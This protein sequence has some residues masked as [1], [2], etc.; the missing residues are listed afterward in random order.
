MTSGIR[1]SVVELH[2]ARL[3]GRFPGASAEAMPDGTW[4]VTVPDV[5]LDDHWNRRTVT[6]WFIAP[7]GYPTAKPDCFWANADL[8]LANGAVPQSASVNVMPGTAEARLWFSWH[9]GAEAWDPVRHD[10]LVYA[11][12]ICRR[13]SEDR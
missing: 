11:N 3:R 13:L 9:L 4:H 7:A 10:L 6:V 2:L 5:G 1:T 8:T 12:A